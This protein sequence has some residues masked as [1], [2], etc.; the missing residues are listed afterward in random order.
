MNRAVFLDRDGVINEI[1][2]QR[3]NFVNSPNDL[4]LL[5]GAAEAIR[6]LN[7]EGYKVC[8]ITNQGG[9]GLGYMTETQLAQIH[10][11]LLALLLEEA[12]AQ[13]D[14]IA[15][16]PNKPQDGSDCRKPKPAMILKLAAKHQIDLAKSYTIGDM[17]TDIMAGNAAGTR[18]ILIVRKELTTSVIEG[19][20]IAFSLLEAVKQIIE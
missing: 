2:T 19:V 13:I 11:K 9:I 16:C 5:P 7:D 18:T 3:V 8:M 12:G 17:M 4:Y 1:K 20:T 15:Y 10:L 14:D 6:I